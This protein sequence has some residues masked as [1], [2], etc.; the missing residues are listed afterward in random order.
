MK[1]ERTIVSVIIFTIKA[2]FFRL[3]KYGTKMSIFP[4]DVV[5]PYN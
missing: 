2:P 1:K 3:H 4:S 5:I